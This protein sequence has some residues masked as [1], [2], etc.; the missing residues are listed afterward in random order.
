LKIKCKKNISKG[1]TSTPDTLSAENPTSTA[2]TT[3]ITT[4]TTATL[5]L[6]QSANL[7]SS[8]GILNKYEIDEQ[9]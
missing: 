6:P 9:K 2:L 8:P 7:Q 1:Q 5:A 4:P 3:A